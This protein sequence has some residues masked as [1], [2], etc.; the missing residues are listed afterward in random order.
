LSID[1]PE[2]AFVKYR[3]LFIC[4]LSIFLLVPSASAFAQ[5]KKDTIRIGVFLPMTGGVASYGQMEWAGI[6]IAR[7]MKPTVLGKEVELFLVDEKSDR[8]EAANAV[9]RLISK[10]KVH[11]LIGSST[12]SNTMAG[13]AI[14]EKAGVP[15][16]SPTATDPRL[17]QNKKYVFRVCFIDS[18]QGEMAARYAFD[19]L[20]ARRA[21]LLIDVAQDACV[22]LANEFKKSFTKKGGKIARTTYCQS[23][24]QDF[25]AQLSSIMASKPD[26]LYLPNYYTEDALIGKQA[27][28][29]GLKTI[30]LSSD[31]AQAPELISI[32]G[33]S[34]EGF[35]LTGHFAKN[36]V[37]SK[38]GKS[39]LRTFTKATKSDVSSYEALGADAY[40]ILLNA[41][42]RAKSTSGPK[43]RAALASTRNF[44]GVSGLIHMGEN[45]NAIKSL[46]VL[47]VK[48]GRFTHM[49]TLNP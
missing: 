30:I 35:L 48:G 43:I 44:E 36:A 2:E 25:T 23:G 47:Q 28:E 21:A 40:F 34:V 9:D 39:F 20:H 46:V 1:L 12:S 5:A 11:A 16:V 13:A 27:A 29:I 6:K 41:I 14:A 18:F 7:D 45:G 22:D 17:T 24:D 49:A 8:I 26:V 37:T 38:L 32:G 33:K 10:N 31:G 42:E 4:L 15:L 3:R 19:N